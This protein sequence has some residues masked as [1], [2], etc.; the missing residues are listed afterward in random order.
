MRGVCHLMIL[1]T[2][3]LYRQRVAQNRVYHFVECDCP[4]R[5]YHL[6]HF[7]NIVTS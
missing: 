4:T 3:W 2:M 7:V 6:M 1:Q 5:I